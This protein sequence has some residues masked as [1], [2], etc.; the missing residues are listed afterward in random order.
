MK[1]G[2][3]RGNASGSQT[4]TMPR[5]DLPDLESN[6]QMC[7]LTSPRYKE[8][9]ANMQRRRSLLS[10]LTLTL[11]TIAI[12]IGISP[13]P[14]RS[15]PAAVWTWVW[16]ADNA[17]APDTVYL[18]ETFRLPSVPSSAILLITADDAYT[19]YL[20]GDKKP[21]AQGADWTTVQQFT[22]T[23]QLTRGLNLIAIRAVN[24]GGLA[25]VLFQNSDHH[26]NRQDVYGLLQ[27]SR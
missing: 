15:D 8:D 11:A 25:G 20:N 4:E 26:A 9:C 18:R 12:T 22:I 10:F 5:Q 24:T 19:A 27:L 3:G 1:Y 23:K 6:M 16:A 17:P 7:V 13:A 2:G 21:V 14:V